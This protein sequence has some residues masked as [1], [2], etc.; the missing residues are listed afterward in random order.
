MAF[1]KFLDPKNDVAFWCIFGTEKNKDIEFLITIMDVEIAS[2]K[3]NIVDV[4]Y[5]DENEVQVI[6]KMQVA[7]TKGFKKRAQLHAAKAYSRQSNNYI[8]L[9]KVFFIAISNSA[10]FPE[11][12]EYISAHSIRDIKTNGYHLKDFQFV[13]IELP[14]FT[15]S[16]VEQ[17]GSTIERWYFFFKYA[18]NTTDKD[19][20]DIVEKFL[21]LK[22]TYDELDKFSWNEK[23]LVVY[24]ERVMDLQKEA[25]ILEYKLD[26]AKG[27]GIKIGQ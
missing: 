24:E 12:V 13:F 16:K 18:E 5:K 20:R 21:M 1:S 3:Q 22:L 14:K 17:L 11:E 15:K 4:L 2:K 25:A 7:K 19:L 27:E 6:V 10:L 26:L 8:N 23:D 9:K